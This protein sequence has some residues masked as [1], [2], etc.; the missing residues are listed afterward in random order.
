MKSI[1]P[2]ER[3]TKTINKL[4][5]ALFKLLKE[6]KTSTI[7]I[8]QL[9]KEAKIY[10]STFYSYFLSIDDLLE[11]FK[12]KYIKEFKIEI[13]QN[14]EYPDKIYDFYIRL[15]NKIYLNQELFYCLYTYDNT[16]IMDKTLE[17]SLNAMVPVDEKAL[18][19]E[20]E[21]QLI[22]T[23]NSYGCNGIIREWLINDCKENIETVAK[24][25]YQCSTVNLHI[26][27]KR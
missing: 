4:E 12:D 19:T 2:D 16:W 10:R 13:Q 15:L 11:Y 3:V 24:I 22:K 21:I 25:L 27:K 7:S 18:L 23:F 8:T 5:K 20:T 17:A 26:V 14:Y 9:C 6:N 1:A